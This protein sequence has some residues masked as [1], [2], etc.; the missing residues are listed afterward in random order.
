[1][2]DTMTS[3]ASAGSEVLFSIE[4]RRFPRV[5]VPNLV[6]GIERAGAETAD[7]ANP[8]GAPGGSSGFTGVG[9]AIDLS[10]DGM[11]LTLPEDIPLGSEVL[12]TFQVDSPDPVGDTIAFVRVPAIVVRRKPGFSTGAVLFL[13]W[14]S[15]DW[16]ALESYLERR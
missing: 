6:V 10:L 16:Q 8:V 9:S 3:F 2:P 4:R 15:A 12:L 1:M 14:E 11:S 5:P 7:P 13:G